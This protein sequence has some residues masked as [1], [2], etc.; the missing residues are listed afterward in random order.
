MNLKERGCY[1][2]IGLEQNFHWQAVNGVL[3]FLLF[4]TFES[5]FLLFGK[6]PTFKQKFLLFPTFKTFFLLFLKYSLKP[7]VRARPESV[8]LFT[9]C[10]VLLS[11]HQKS[12]DALHWCKKDKASFDPFH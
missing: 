9:H 7:K 2:K 4:P 12:V 3:L 8:L 1:F 5:F 6:C 11:G 10:L